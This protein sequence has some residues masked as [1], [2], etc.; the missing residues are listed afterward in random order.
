[1]TTPQPGAG[2]TADGTPAALAAKITPRRVS[3]YLQATAGGNYRTVAAAY[4]GATAQTVRNWVRIA[5]REEAIWDRVNPSRPLAELAWEWLE[6]HDHWG[7]DNGNRAPYA[8]DSAALN[9]PPP[10]PIP[11]GYWRC[12]ITSILLERAES[13]AEV[14]AVAQIR[15][16]GRDPQHW[17]AASAFLERRWPNRWGRRTQLELSG[18]DGAPIQMQA[19]PSIEDMLLRVEQ[20]AVGARVIERPDPDVP[21]TREGDRWGN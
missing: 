8:A 6:E 18:T 7:T 17:Q 10:I 5:E 15:T 4:A 19:V 16:A 13:E 21:F 14:T 9:D 12:V 2:F 11:S 20:L 3:R 1:M